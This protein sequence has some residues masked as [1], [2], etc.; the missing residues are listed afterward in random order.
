MAKNRA[1][2]IDRDGVINNGGEVVWQKE[3]LQIIPGAGEA[4][5]LL[6]DHGFL[7]IVLTNQPVVA[8]GWATEQDVA[9]LNRE[10]DRRIGTSGAKIDKWYVC[11]HHPLAGL[12]EYPGLPEYRLDCEDRKP[13]TGMIKKA[14]KEFDI[15]VKE[16]FVIGDLPADIKMGRDAGCKTI[17][18]KTGHAGIEPNPKRAYDIKSDYTAANLLEAVKLIINLKP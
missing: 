9:E 15:D 10:I 6:N 1:V 12:P 5:K 8:R 4:L 13:K 7:V 2:F 11:P 18:V 17:L 14:E 16:S 3:K